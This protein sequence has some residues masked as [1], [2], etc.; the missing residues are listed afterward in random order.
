MVPA[1]S[2]LRC[3]FV[4]QPSHDSADA[5]LFRL[6]VVGGEGVGE[7]G[8]PAGDVQN[9]NFLMLKAEVRT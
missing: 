6:V 5:A 3:E 9:D 4:C 2:S 1:Y 7:G 8:V